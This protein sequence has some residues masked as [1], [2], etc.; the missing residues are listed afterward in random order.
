M[1]E[2]ERRKGGETGTDL[3]DSNCLQNLKQFGIR[4]PASSGF[5]I[6]IYPLF[7]CICA[8]VCHAFDI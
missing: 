4:Y 2:G 3:D 6:Y 1:W 7:W 5:C 8:R